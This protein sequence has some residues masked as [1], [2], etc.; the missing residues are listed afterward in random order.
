MPSEAVSGS[1]QAPQMS[2]AS[3]SSC[4][5]NSL[6]HTPVAF[7][8]M[9][10]LH[11]PQV[12]AFRSDQATRRLSVTLKSKAQQQHLVVSRLLSYFHQQHPTLIQLL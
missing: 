7:S 4:A 5:Q 9:Q 3:V 8:S 11:S 10:A 6:Q 2:P 12:P 1:V